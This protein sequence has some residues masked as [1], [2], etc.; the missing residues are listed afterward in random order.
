[1]EVDGF[2]KRRGELPELSNG[3]PARDFAMQ[4][5]TQYAS[6]SEPWE[7]YAISRAVHQDLIQLV[8]SVHM[9]DV[10]RQPWSARK[11]GV[12]SARFENS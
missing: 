2:C 11:K 12:S 7:A 10:D 8:A 1:M 5:W 9:A 4:C 3:N 6:V